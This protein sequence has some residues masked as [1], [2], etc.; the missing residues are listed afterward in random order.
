MKIIDQISGLVKNACRQPSNVFGYSAWENHI[1]S[2]VK[3]A[4]ILARKT[5]A[6]SEIVEIA[7]LLHDYAS[8]LNK[9][10]YPEHHIHGARLAREVLVKYHYSQEKIEQ[11][12]NCILAHRGSKVV[13]KKSLEAK[14]LADADALAHFANVNALFYLAYVVKKFDVKDGTEF[15]LAKLARSWRK[16]SPEA[17]DMCRERY[18]SIKKWL[19]NVSSC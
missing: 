5:G 1:V 2:V 19:Q 14:V 4:K 9:D 3:F 18:N 17:K 12:A 10:Y 11:V 16:L 6:N 8:V 13:V 15:V 7:A